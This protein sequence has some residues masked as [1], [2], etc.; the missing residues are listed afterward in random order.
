MAISENLFGVLTGTTLYLLTRLG[1]GG[2]SGGGMGP[3]Q[4]QSQ[5][6]FSGQGAADA[7]TDQ[8]EQQFQIAQERVKALQ[9]E[10]DR[11]KLE[12]VALRLE[13]AKQEAE[14]KKRELEEARRARPPYPVEQVTPSPPQPQRLQREDLSLELPPRATPY[15]QELTGL[16]L[17]P[18]WVFKMEEL[19]QNELRHVEVGDI[20]WVG[21]LIDPFGKV[22]ELNWPLPGVSSHEYAE[23]VGL[24]PG[25]KRLEIGN[26]YYAVDK[27]PSYVALLRVLTASII[28]GVDR[29]RANVGPDAKIYPAVWVV[30]PDQLT[31]QYLFSKT[32]SLDMW[33]GAIR[34]DQRWVTL[35]ISGLQN[36]ERA[37]NFGLYEVSSSQ[38]QEYLNPIWENWMA[39]HGVERLEDGPVY[40]LAC[41]KKKNPSICRGLEEAIQEGRGY[42]SRHGVPDFFYDLSALPQE[43][44]RLT[45]RWRVFEK[46]PVVEHRNL[47]PELRQIMY[48]YFRYGNPEKLQ[49]MGVNL[50]A[51]DYT[52]NPQVEYVVQ[53]KAI[54]TFRQLYRRRQKQLPRL[55]QLMQFLRPQ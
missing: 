40:H 38:I 25:D 1:W 32:F 48:D 52:R 7:A 31:F 39:T 34:S 53:S 8:I 36:P 44:W 29:L 24:E 17:T 28:D 20:P 10:Y 33:D 55:S 51:L 30:L 27:D 14:R 18:Y 42:R 6:P 47:E 22:T 26:D 3:G 16:E 9:E 50:D 13:A 46:V 12:E 37:A 19:P 5:V 4:G 41:V 23:M 35:D 49:G 11:T 45:L 15:D 21:K 2:G 43:I 54:Q